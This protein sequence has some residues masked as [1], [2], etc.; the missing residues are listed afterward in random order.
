[1]TR[2]K[3]DGAERSGGST[4]R[5]ASGARGTPRAWLFQAAERLLPAAL[6]HEDMVVRNRVRFMVGLQVLLALIAASMLI[7]RWNEGLVAFRVFAGILLVMSAGLLFAN[8]AGLSLGRTSTST[9][10]LYFGASVGLTIASGGESIP[11]VMTSSLVPVAAYGILGRRP[12]ALWT[13]A[14]IAGI[15][16]T[17]IY[18]G[19]TDEY[20]YGSDM[21]AWEA[22]RYPSMVLMVGFVLLTVLGVD[23]L[24]ER[25]AAEARALQEQLGG[26]VERYRDLVENVGDCMMEYDAR[27]RC[28]YASPN[29][30][31]LMGRAP[32]TLLGHGYL[33]CLHPEDLPDI[34]R[35][36]AALSAE[37]GTTRK[38]KSRVRHVRGHWIEGEVSARTFTDRNGELHMVTI[39]R[40]LS[41]VYRAQRAIRHNDRLAT[42][43]TL[44]AGIAHQIN[45]PIGA[46]RN[47]SEYALLA[48]RDGDLESIDDV[49]RSN[50]EQSAR[51]GEI[52]RSLLQFASRDQGE[53]RTQD[54]RSVVERACRLMGS[55]AGERGTRVHSE[56]PEK[57]LSVDISDVQIE[58]VI[59]NLVQNAIHARPASNRVEV[60]VTSAA[61]EAVVEVRDDGCG[62]SE[63]DLDQVFDPF[64]TT[65]LEEGGHG[66]GLSVALGIVREHG[67]HLEVE[68]R[69]EEGTCVR[70]RL[71]LARDLEGA[72][73]P[74][75]RR[76]AGRA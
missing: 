55:T 65:R 30:E 29:W 69:L 74:I 59:V 41:E 26:Q 5:R 72:A 73:P 11:A 31:E 42:T 16:V 71:P 76:S 44:A 12:A 62:I 51:C 15:G 20:L 23:W 3:R 49:L 1:M 2:A 6:R 52:V 35:R 75:A 46:I 70:L 40:D 17:A 7:G 50:I 48:A 58:Q 67:G 10:A 56:V 24:L 53:K 13:F 18:A 25:S 60:V 47:A 68:S 8:R 43:G 9:V 32:E 66:L 54:L 33:D 36:S 61:G 14:V 21:L 28:L 22:W 38:Y 64:F 4:A 34:D 27:F 37:P 45:N 63:Q 19:T 57:A 39:F